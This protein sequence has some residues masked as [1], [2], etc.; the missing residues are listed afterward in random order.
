MSKTL[1]KALRIFISLT[2]ILSSVSFSKVQAGEIVVPLMPKPGTIVNLSPMYNPAFLNGLVI[3]PDNALEFDF[4]IRKGDGNLDMPQKNQEYTKLVKYF[5]ASLTIPDEDQWVN[6]SPYENDRIIKDNFGKTEMG[7]DLLSQDYLLKQ[8]ASSLMYPESGLGK[9]FWDK[10][11]E[12]AYQEFGNTNIPVNTFNKVWIVPDEASIYESGN[13]AYVVKSHLKVMLEEDYLSLE[14]HSAVSE[15]P[16]KTHALSSKVIKEIILPQI[17]REVNEG[18]NFAQ[19]RQIFSGM[20]LATW[21]KKALRESLLGKI[22][23]DRAKVAG[24]NQDPAN[25]EKIYQQYLAA[26]KKG[27]YNYIKEDVDRYTNQIIPRKYFSGGFVNQLDRAMV[28]TKVNEGALAQ[29]VKV[30]GPSDMDR[31]TVS[32]KGDQERMDAAMR[33]SS[34]LPGVNP[35]VLNKQPAMP[36][37]GSLSLRELSAYDQIRL[38]NKGILD[39]SI[40]ISGVDG[41]MLR[42]TLMGQRAEVYFRPVVSFSYRQHENDPA[43]KVFY[44]IGY[45]PVSLGDR[46][47]FNLRVFY[48]SEDET[49]WRSY[50]PSNINS[51]DDLS[52]GE[53]VTGPL[54]R[55]LGRLE[56]EGIENG[57]DHTGFRLAV[58]DI[59][60]KRQNDDKPING[61]SKPEFVPT[62]LEDQPEI[63]KDNIVDAY[64]RAGVPFLVLSSR[65]KQYRWTFAQR[66]G[67]VDV[68]Q[69]EDLRAGITGP[70]GLQGR[71]IPWTLPPVSEQSWSS[72]TQ[73]NALPFLKDVMAL[74]N[75]NNSFE[76]SK[77]G[78]TPVSFAD[79]LKAP[80]MIELPSG[81]VLRLSMGLDGRLIVS[82]GQSSHAVRSGETVTYGARADLHHG[83]T[84]LERLGPR[85]GVSQAHFTLT[86]GQD[87]QGRGMKG[88]VWIKDGAYAKDG[89]TTEE[90]RNF[91]A[92]AN[93][94]PE[95]VTNF[96]RWM[97]NLGYLGVVEGNVRLYKLFKAPVEDPAFAK[98]RV[99]MQEALG[100]ELTNAL[101]ATYFQRPS[102]NGS[103]I[104]MYSDA[105]MA[106]RRTAIASLAASMLLTRDA[107]GQAINRSS[108]LDIQDFMFNFHAL[109][110]KK[111]LSDAD[112]ETLT[113]GMSFLAQQPQ[114]PLDATKAKVFAER[115]NAFSAYKSALEKH[116]SKEQVQQYNVLLGTMFLG[117]YKPGFSEEVSGDDK[118]I[119][120]ALDDRKV[121]VEYAK[122]YIDPA[123]AGMTVADLSDKGKQIYAAIGQVS[124]ESG[125]SFEVALETVNSQVRAAIALYEQVQG[126]STGNLLPAVERAF[127]TRYLVGELVM[128]RIK[129]GAAL[130]LDNVKNIGLVP[131]E[132]TAEIIKQ[133]DSAMAAGRD[134]AKAT[135][136]K[137]VIKG[138]G[139][140]G[141]F[142]TDQ[143]PDFNPDISIL[144]AV[145]ISGIRSTASGLAMNSGVPVPKATPEQ[146]AELRKGLD[147]GDGLFIKSAAIPEEKIV[148]KKIIAV[149]ENG[150]RT[151]GVG[152]RITNGLVGIEVPVIVSMPQ[153]EFRN[154]LQTALS[155]SKFDPMMVF[156]RLRAQEV[157]SVDANEVKVKEGNTTVILTDA[158]FEPQLTSLLRPFLKE[159]NKTEVK[160]VKPAA[161]LDSDGNGI[162]RANQAMSADKKGGIDLNAANLNFQI[163]R[164][165][166]GVPLPLPQQDMK[167]LQGI[168]GFI[169]T[170]LEIKPV[171]TLP[172][173]SSLKESETQ[174]LA[175]AS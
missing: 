21:Y 124:Q 30:Q 146:L 72:L 84:V 101:L 71:N 39:K 68:V 67:Y 133:S 57:N 42:Y 150:Q 1:Q 17:E 175:S 50:T 159:F 38:N 12:K 81:D 83:L 102:T 3:H 89:V 58:N 123:M 60:V 126:M 16:N 8:I 79:I 97:A 122:L 26:F 155:G 164:N 117:F 37:M 14:K 43:K 45:E 61:F 29:A 80:V 6:L 92:A 141:G 105:A 158:G 145:T 73:P 9:N 64:N 22:Y 98:T 142:V 132:V 11:Y 120:V 153:V 140:R 23:A 94:N 27:V 93:K 10:V 36:P 149:A 54:Q 151:S 160:G 7:R 19:L 136:V 5:L 65:N 121:F 28:V 107:S 69:V 74:F 156:N 15:K 131:N 170:I 174:V 148:G 99:A 44:A 109:T 95:G 90:I 134:A 59:L 100:D 96:F 66:S 152:V 32:L 18:K 75:R 47:N 25:N 4:L 31:A 40:T 165:G 63:S 128:P 55:D 111:R 169:P 166:R 115:L 143:L 108:F 157:I 104:S 162:W 167:M 49:L 82:D 48:R 163:K 91:V 85:S 119:A 118:Q 56:D 20:V 33:T 130:S 76:I 46:N 24:V 51:V 161:L 110:D 116:G 77:A 34:D 103:V 144:P 127:L 147:A 168:E 114:F 139:M 70:L 62:R 137:G 52:V 53:V 112:R 41:Q 88:Y 172:M 106:S 154:K 2:F 138:V 113:A 135:F 86:V 173:F 35:V 171:T 125:P 78:V 87:D 129:R 13:T